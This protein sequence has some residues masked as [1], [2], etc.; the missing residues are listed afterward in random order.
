ME[1]GHLVAQPLVFLIR[2]RHLAD[3]RVGT[4]EPTALP[5]MRKSYSGRIIP[6]ALADSRVVDQPY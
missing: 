2:R 4:K 1:F 3:R 6:L 5:P